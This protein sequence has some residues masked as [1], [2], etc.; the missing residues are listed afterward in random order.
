MNRRSDTYARFAFTIVLILLVC[1]IFGVGVVGYANPQ[2]ART[3]SDQTST[4]T[5][6]PTQGW[7]TSTPEAQGMDSQKL[8]LMLET[9][10]QQKLN[11]HSLLVIRN[12][13]LVSETYFQFYKEQTKHELYSC[14]KSFIAT[15][16]GI[17]SDQGSIDRLNHPVLD[18]F[19]ERTIENRDTRKEAMT[20]DDLLT[21]RAGLDW[22]EGDPIYRAMYLSSD[23]V[24]FVLDKPMRAQP[25][26]QFNYC[27]GCSHVLSAIIQQEIGMNTQDFAQQKLFAP[28]G[29]AS[30]NW[31]RDRQGI[32]LGGW[33]LQIT[34]R[35]MAKLGYLYLHN[36]MWDG[37]QIVSAEWVKTATQKHTA[38]DGKLGYGYQW[39]IYPSLGAY[40][41]LGR[42]G[43]TIFVIPD[44]NVIVVTTADIGGHDEIFKLIE[45][46]I[47]PAVQKP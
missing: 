27:S 25:G 29:I 1:L 43:Q 14:T 5:Y 22:Q 16:V 28:L 10:K 41:A 26:S 34:P 38:T 13:Y 30:L 9:V 20:V 40:T 12:G 33:G 42:A 31:D 4:S 19:P 2:P 44:L 47:P 45:Q 3:S 35:D 32:S 17:A 7:R 8:T 11:L 24:K 6:W 18:F 15:L 39:W 36:G 46:Y 37:Q 21:M 23:W